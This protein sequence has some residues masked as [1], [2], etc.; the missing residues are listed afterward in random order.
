MLTG[1]VGEKYFKKVEAECAAT[2]FADAISGVTCS[3]MTVLKI[4]DDRLKHSP[5]LMPTPEAIF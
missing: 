3:A 1:G 5:A 2:T 4:G